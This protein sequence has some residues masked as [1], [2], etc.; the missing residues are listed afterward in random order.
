MLQFHWWDYG[1]EAYLEA[2]GHLNQ[3]RE[4]GLIRHLALTNFDTPHLE[5]IIEH[6]TPVVSNQVQ[7]SLV[8][9]R[10]EVAMA[11]VCREHGIGLLTYGTLCGGLL[12]ARYLGRAEPTARELTT[13]SLRK[14]KQ[15]VDAWG[16]WSLFQMLLQALDPIARRYGVSIAN[17][18]TR[19]VLDRPAVAGV[20]VGVRLGVADHHEE[21]AR[22]FDFHMEPQDI[23]DIQAVVSKGRDL[24]RAIG[25]CGDEYR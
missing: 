4:E 20:I 1:N 14:Y 24:Y 18:A 10:P 17:L 16:G 3:M 21:N 13:A 2:L 11:D 5:R 22:V 15:M 9:R 12:S 19:Y 23:E 7:Y 25:D 8:D 6:G